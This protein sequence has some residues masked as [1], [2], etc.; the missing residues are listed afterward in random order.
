M[1]TI[2][3]YVLK[4]QHRTFLDLIRLYN[5]LLN[6]SSSHLQWNQKF[7]QNTYS[8]WL[9]YVLLPRVDPWLGKSTNFCP[10][11]HFCLCPSTLTTVCWPFACPFRI[12]A[13][14]SL[15]ISLPTHSL[16][17]HFQPALH[18][19]SWNLAYFL[20]NNKMIPMWYGNNCNGRESSQPAPWLSQ[21]LRIRI[22][23]KE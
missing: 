5:V 8:L 1:V 13:F 18:W 15:R 19:Y 4:E 22:L 21:L 3:L 20:K 7:L 9:R 14:F 17:C 12:D 2:Y 11:Y 16:E 23:E 10:F 6:S